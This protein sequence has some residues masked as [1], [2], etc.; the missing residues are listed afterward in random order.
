MRKKSRIASHNIETLV[1]DNVRSIIDKSQDALV[2][3]ITGR[4][5]GIDAILELFDNGTIT[6]NYAFLQIKGKQ[7]KVEHLKKSKAVSCKISSANAYYAN[8]NTLPV[9]VILASIEESNNFFFVPLQEVIT[10]EHVRKLD[11]GQKE[12]TIRIPLDNC[13]DGNIDPLR[14]IIES[15]YEPNNRDGKKAI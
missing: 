13:V 2:R 11:K 4:D 8:Q 1:L 14:K 10:K 6:G 15:Y 5:Y 9:I 7:K 12:I 3:E